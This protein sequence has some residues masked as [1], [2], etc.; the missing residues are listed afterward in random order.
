M[1]GGGGLLNIVR[2]SQFQMA[3]TKWGVSILCR[4]KM[5]DLVPLKFGHTIALVSPS[6]HVYIIGGGALLN[7]VRHSQFLYAEHQMGGKHIMP[8]KNP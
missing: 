2:H 1:G 8:F 3:N 4:S 5:P 6:I 7:M